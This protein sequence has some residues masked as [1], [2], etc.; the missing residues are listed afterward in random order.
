MLDQTKEFDPFESASAPAVQTYDL[1]GKVEINA[2]ACA[3]V[4]GQGKVPFDPQTHDKRFTAIDVFIQNLPEIDIKYPKSLERHWIAESKEWANITLKS[5]KDCG[6]DNVREING[7]W[8]RVTMVP[9]G[10]KYTNSNGEPK[11]E[12]T[13]KFLAFYAD[14]DECR[15]M[16]LAN[17]GQPSNG[18]NVA[19]SA[20]V[21]NEDKE[22]ETQKAFLK[23]VVA[24]AARGQNDIEEVKKILAPAIA[25]Y[26]SVA[27]YF[28]VDSPETLQ[29]IDEALPFQP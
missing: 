16:Y 29:L 11:E 17:G 10:K 12:T 27:K 2:W 15:A 19:T 24:N 20:P 4:K 26:P 6:F 13:F 28:T 25:A 9:N 5:I 8:A 21:S 14:E 7:K 1:F 3:L 18:H 22:K 23:V